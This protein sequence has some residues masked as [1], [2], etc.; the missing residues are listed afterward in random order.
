MIVYVRIERWMRKRESVCVCKCV[1]IEGVCY[2]EWVCSY[3]KR[4]CFC[5]EGV[6]VFV[7]IS[8]IDEKVSSQEHGT[9]VVFSG[10]DMACRSPSICCSDCGIIDCFF[11]VFRLVVKS[12]RRMT[13]IHRRR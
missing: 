10:H 9:Y 12:S 3:S 1:C 8:S 7:C 6:G 5:L 11:S 4:E 13:D 2:I